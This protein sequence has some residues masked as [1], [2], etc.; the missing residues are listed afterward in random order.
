MTRSQIIALIAKRLLNRT[1]LDVDILN[2][3]DLAQATALE[4]NGRLLPWFL[5]SEVATTDTVVGEER[6][7]VP[8]DFA[9][10][11]EGG[12]LFIYD[13][14]AGDEPWIKLVKDDYDALVQ[15]YQDA[16]ERPSHYS[17]GG[18]YFR[19]KPTPNAIYPVKQIYFAQDTA[20]SLLVDGNAT[21]LWLTYAPDL[22]IAVV[23][24][25]IASKYLQDQELAGSFNQDI[26][27]AWDRIN[28]ET[29]AQQHTNR[30][31]VMGDLD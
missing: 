29:E 24:Q 19:L 1:D 4:R 22:M 25:A 3:M 7:A 5:E 8:D 12:G 14:T 10:E 2:E 23:A 21:N 15:T 18:R 27:R 16:Q 28:V 31:Y 17:L 30:E 6:I 26:T 11:K 9:M 13:S 20:P